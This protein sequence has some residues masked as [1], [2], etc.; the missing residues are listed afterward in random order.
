[1]EVVLKACVSST[2]EVEVGHL[3]LV[4][5]PIFLKHAMRTSVFWIWE[6]CH[7][8]QVFFFQECIDCQCFSE[9]LRSRR[10]V[11]M[12]EVPPSFEMIEESFQSHSYREKMGGGGEWL[13]CK[14][15]RAERSNPKCK[16]DSSGFFTS[17][18]NKHWW[19]KVT[20]MPATI[21]NCTILLS[22]QRY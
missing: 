11:I 14:I 10:Q 8:L 1:M 6:Y 2:S 19:H 15:S 7:F 13:R 9:S 21:K 4:S 3:Y 17:G 12:W 18:R 20:V 5:V 16:P 22:R